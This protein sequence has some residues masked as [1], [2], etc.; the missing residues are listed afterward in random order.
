MTDQRNKLKELSDLIDE[1]TRD[2]DV[3]K[4]NKI[5]E[6]ETINLD[7]EL[8]EKSRAIKTEIR[9]VNEMI[10]QVE[11]MIEV[12]SDVNAIDHLKDYNETVK[13]NSIAAEMMKYQTMPL[14]QYYQC[15]NTNCTV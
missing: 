11:G 10:Q 5:R 9:S 8:E 13:A 2:V 15:N 7:T 6:A 12:L 14:L 4:E 1:I 3:M